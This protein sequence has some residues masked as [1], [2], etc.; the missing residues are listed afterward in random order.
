MIDHG[1]RTRTS[2]GTKPTLAPFHT[3]A[4]GYSALVASVLKFGVPV[5]PSVQ[6][7]DLI[8]PREEPVNLPNYSDEHALNATS[9]YAMST[10]KVNDA[11]REYQDSA[12]L[13]ELR[14]KLK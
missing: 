7:T 2:T 8:P 13:G 14:Q 1:H 5:G 11:L 9:A 3:T 12:V 6:A 10:F 4:E